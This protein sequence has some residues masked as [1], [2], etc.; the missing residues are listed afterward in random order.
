ML[1]KVATAQGFRL[2]FPEEFGGMP[3]TS[4]ELPDEMVKP[5]DVTPP[6]KKEDK[7]CD[8]FLLIRFLLNPFLEIPV[9][10]F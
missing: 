5:K 1:K 2:C 10:K 6:K 9:H 8:T 4:D 3:Y 7:N